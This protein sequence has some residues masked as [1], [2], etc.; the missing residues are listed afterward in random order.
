MTL[1]F[2]FPRTL[3]H[4]T[5]TSVLP[6]V[7]AQGLLPRRVS[8]SSNWTHSVE[9][10]EDAVYL[11]VAYALHYATTCEAPG[12]PC[13]LEIDAQALDERLFAADE[14]GVAQLPAGRKAAGPSATLEEATR[15][16]RERIHEVHASTSLSSLGNCTY[17]GVI[18]AEAVR[19]VVV[20]SVP[21]ATRLTLQVCDPVVTPM[22]YRLLG[23][24]YREFCR[25]LFD[26]E[27]PYPLMD[28]RVP[29]PARA[30]VPLGESLRALAASG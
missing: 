27:G 14:D 10:R 12:E 16:W 2:E 25:W 21:E 19:R 4:G 5:R 15:F 17:F 11:T 30:A 7:A 23:D 6:S 20:L 9:S 18:P 26:P 29:R 3:Y 1:P 24:R 22:N 8:G 13:L 28:P